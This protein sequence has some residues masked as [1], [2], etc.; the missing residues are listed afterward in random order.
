[1]R[2]SMPSKSPIW[3]AAALA[4]KGLMSGSGPKDSADR[5][6]LMESG[7]RPN[8][9]KVGDQWV[10]YQLAQPLSVQASVIANAFESWR[11]ER[12]SASMD[13]AAN[14]RGWHCSSGRSAFILVGSAKPV[15]SHV[16]GRRAYGNARSTGVAPA[17]GPCPDRRELFCASDERPS[18]CQ[19]GRS[20]ARAGLGRTAGR[21]D[22]R[23]V[24]A[25]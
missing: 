2:N 15:R 9:L 13:S 23:C 5:A 6:A 24:Y 4:A 10:S 12:K 11:G 19:R 7:W 21:I 16:T 20:Q 14:R 25:F 18:W 22:G 3:K 17:C 8:S 1:M